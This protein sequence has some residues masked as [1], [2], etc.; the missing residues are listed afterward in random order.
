MKKYGPFLAIFF[1][2]LAFLM[3]HLFTHKLILGADAPFH[4]NRFYDAAQ[5][6]KYGDF[7]YFPS[8]YGFQQ[9]GRIVNAVYGPFFAYLQGLI[10]LLAG[11]WFHYQILSNFILY[12]ISGFSMLILLRYVNVR[13][14]VS[15]PVAVLFMSTYSIQYWSINQGFTSWGTCFYPLCMIPIADFVLHKK[16]PVIKVAVSVGL[17]TQIHLLSSIMLALMYIPFYLY[18]FFNQTEKG[19]A[20]L[21]LIKSVLLYFVLTANIWA[22]LAIVYS[23]N[24]ILP[25]FVNREMSQKAIDLDGSYWLHYPKAFPILILSG[26]L[27]FIFFQQKNTLFQKIVLYT[28]LVFFFLST[29]LIPWTTLIEKNVPFISLIQFPFR[30]FVPFTLLLL[31][32]LALSLNQWSEQKWFRLLSIFGIL[33]FSAQT[34]QNLYQHLEKWENETFVS[35]HTYLFDTPEEARKTFFSKDM[36][37]SLFVFQKT[38]PDYLPI[39]KETKDNKYDRYNEEILENETT[40]IKTHPGGLLTIKW[41]NTGDKTVHI[42]VIVY[43][44][45]VLQQNGKTLTDYEVTDIGTPIVKQ[46]KGINELTLHYQTPIYFY[47][48]L[49]L[50]LI[51]WFT[52]L[53]LFIYHRYKLLRA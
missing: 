52:L 45:T 6:I 35:R 16:F 17:M 27:L 20:L 42:P 21:Q 12:L 3:P 40:F 14:W 36:S 11:S 9:S 1:I 2:A 18:Y 48:I 22:G 13:N 5:Q 29:S 7:H 38:T 28:S 53:C 43:D 47:F 44:R 50:T 8:L 10:V 19:K 33:I 49:S 4:Y 23:G 39:Y 31:L 30:F 15:V 41:K 25:P 37:T 51:G 24:K 46:K 34:I 26:F 32:Y